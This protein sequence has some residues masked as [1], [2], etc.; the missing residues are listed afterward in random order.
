[1][2]RSLSSEAFAEIHASHRDRILRYL[3]RMTRDLPRAE[4]LTQETFL[5][6]SRA[7]GDFRGEAKVSTWLYRIAANLWLDERRKE[8]A[9][10]RQ[11]QQLPLDPADA[12]DTASLSIS[13]PKL[14]DQL[15]EESEMGSCVREFVDRLPPDHRVAII[16]HDLEGLKNREIAAILGCSLDAVKIRIHRARGRLKVLLSGHCDFYYDDRDVLRCDRKQGGA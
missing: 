5:R 9:R 4:E 16:L 14:P 12:P 7:L 11:A 10:G 13:G 3:H 1:M 2:D 6:A 8:S 15:L